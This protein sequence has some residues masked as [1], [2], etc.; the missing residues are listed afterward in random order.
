MPSSFFLRLNRWPINWYQE[1]ET[2]LAIRIH[3][4][5]WILEIIHVIFFIISFL[6]ICKTWLF[7]LVNRALH[8]RFE[9]GMVGLS[10]CDFVG[11][12]VEKALMAL[13]RLKEWPRRF[14]V[15]ISG[16]Y[17]DSNLIWVLFF[18][19]LFWTP[20][21]PPLTNNLWFINSKKKITQKTQ[22]KLTS[23]LSL[24]VF[25]NV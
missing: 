10:F 12:R 11:T 16:L 22:T 25:D 13:Y 18:T 14:K 15:Q 8:L 3:L 9:K 6:H 23:K 5:A 2:A 21:L 19:F 17:L 7:P 4:C 24:N 1:W 20:H